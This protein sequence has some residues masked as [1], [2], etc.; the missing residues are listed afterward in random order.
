MSRVGEFAFLVGTQNVGKSTLMRQLFDINSRNLVIPQNRSTE[1]WNDCTEV[2]WERIFEESTQTPA[3]EAKRVFSS[4]AKLKEKM[5]FTYHLGLYLHRMEGN[6]RIYIDHDTQYLFAVLSDP[7]YGFKNGGLFSDDYTNYIPTLGKLPS[8]V[9]RLVTDRRD[10]R[11]DLF[12]AV[13]GFR[14]INKD[15]FDWSPSIYLFR[16]DADVQS[17]EQKLPEKLVRLIEPVK[18]RVDTISNRGIATDNAAQRCHCEIIHATDVARAN[19]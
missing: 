6:N 17:A 12:F 8:Y 5:N 4:N 9:Q 19:A 14:K 7:K 18:R 13:H 11:R 15:F 2:P 1:I 3:F 16:T 10:D